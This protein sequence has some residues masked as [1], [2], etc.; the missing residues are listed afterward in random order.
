MKDLFHMSFSMPARILYTMVFVGVAGVAT[1]QEQWEKEGEGE[2]KNMEIEMTKERRLILP[3]ANRYFEKIPPR[4][5]EPIVPA[6]TYDIKRFS[7]SS[8]D[9]QAT[10]RPLRLKQEELNKQY[11]NYLSG[12]FGNYSSFFLEGSVATKRDKS[13]LVGADF[14]WRGFGKGPVDADHSSNSVARFT[15]FGKKIFKDVTLSGDLGYYSNRLYFYGYTPGADVDRDKLQQVYDD[16]SVSAIVEN[17]RKGDINYQVKGGYS[18]LRD[19]YVSS[20]G[21]LHLGLK[22]NYS[23]KAGARLILDA[24]IFIINQKDSLFSLSRNLVWIQ[25]AYEFVPLENLT[26]T[27]GLNIAFTNDP[28]TD[29]SI[30]AY[31]HLRGR[32]GFGEQAALYASVSGNMDKVN[33]HTLT[34]E[35]PWL[36]S[37]VPMAHT[38]RTIDIDGGMEALLGKKLTTRFGVSY[39]S[40]KNLY[41]YKN[42]RDGFDL[43]GQP[44]GTPFDKF[45]LV[46]DKTTGRLNPYGEATFAQSDAFNVTLRF[47]YFQYAM[48][49]IAQPWHRPTYRGNVQIRYDLYGK[50]FLQAGVVAQGGMK[51]LDPSNSA[52]VTLEPAWDVSFRGRYFFSRQISAFLHLDNMLANE[53]PLF[54]SYP[55]RGFQA[56]IG[57]SWSF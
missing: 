42:R 44:V 4:P 55:S 5:F 3:R 52:E 33:L 16:F 36:D 24:D 17:S 2:I 45:T 8:P 41:F 31:P 30:H 11:G 15:M 37:N 6:I 13:K 22:S 43:G 14:S 12:G 23:L 39:A 9:F 54:L 10:H 35:N 25:P 47:D 49:A 21:E 51:A 50:I 20:E 38:N 7:F 46:Y 18:H 53:Y 19:L 56:L 29:G 40:L 26:V 57:A 48:E 34:T 27:A 1:G 28:N 32:Y